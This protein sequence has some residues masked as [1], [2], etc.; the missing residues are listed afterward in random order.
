MPAGN[1]ALEVG[2]DVLDA[3]SGETELGF[4]ELVGIFA[5]EDDVA[6][7]AE[8]ARG[9]GG[10]LAGERDVERAG[11]VGGG[12]VGGGTGVEKDCAFRLEAF[13]RVG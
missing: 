8:D 10:V 12:E 3:N 9:P 1:A 7:E 11:D 6:V 5:D 2:V 4:A 13:D